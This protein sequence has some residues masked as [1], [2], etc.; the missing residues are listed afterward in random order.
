MD[1]RVRFFS[2]NDLSIGFYL[3]RVEQVLSD[4]SYKPTLTIHDAIELYEC[5]RFMT[6]GIRANRWDD[7][8][9]TEL[10]AASEIAKSAACKRMREIVA[11]D[12]LLPI[13][14]SLDFDYESP[15]WMLFEF[16][17][18]WDHVDGE[19]MA[20]VLAA[21]PNQLQ[22]ILRRKRLTRA[23]DEILAES[24]VA[25]P[26]IGI[27]IILQASRLRQ[28]G[29]DE[30]NIPKA[31]TSA[32]FENMAQDYVSSEDANS[33]F[34][35]VLANKGKQGESSSSRLTLSPKTMAS[36]KKAYD[37]QMEDML[38]NATGVTFGVD[39][40]IDP[41]Q[42]PCRFSSSRIWKLIIPTA[43]NG[44]TCIRTTQPS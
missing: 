26:M 43:E 34:L 32:Q 22:N 44:S 33:N 16:S 25:N 42:I 30:Y 21:K 13:I 38:Q 11:N 41:N 24:L 31:L 1:R 4:P 10:R 35:A 36:A 9:Y 6:S 8:W 37:A 17:S 27:P 14:D 2:A 3:D 39:V 7:D 12:D 28:T 29:L 20:K 15:F 18:A 5:Y 23:Y 40:C 19:Q